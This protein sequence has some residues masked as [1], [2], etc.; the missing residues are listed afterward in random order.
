MLLR[1]AGEHFVWDLLQGNVVAGDGGVDPALDGFH[2]R[3]FFFC[4][5]FLEQ[6]H[7]NISFTDRR[8]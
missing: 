5:Q 8:K 2:L 7:S 1:T 6:C 4:E 3:C